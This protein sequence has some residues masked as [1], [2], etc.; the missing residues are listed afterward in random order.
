MTKT[1]RVVALLLCM[2]NYSIAYA[3]VLSQALTDYKL[4]AYQGMVEKLE[5]FKP[6][7]SDLS[8]KF[9]LLGIG[10]NRLQNYEKGATALI[11]AARFKNDSPDLWYELGQALYATSALRKA[12]TAFKKS[13]S[14]NYKKPESLYYVA[15]ISQILED[16]KTARDVYVQ[17]IENPGADSN[18]IQA[19]RFQLG[20]VL[21]SMAETRDDAS[22]LVESYVLPQFIK[23]QEIVPQSDIATEIDA[24]IK[25]IKTRY[26][27]DPNRMRNGRVLPEKRWAIDFQQEIN[28]DNNVTLATDVPTSQ[29]TQKESYVFDST[30]SAQYVSSFK[31]R[32][33][34]EP[35][36]RINQKKYAETSEPTVY[37]NDSYDITAGTVFKIEH[38][39]KE[40]PASFGIGLDYKY[41]A[42]DRL[43]QKDRIY[44]ARSTTLSFFETL[45]LT[46]WG[47]TTFRFKYKDYSAYQS[48]LDNTTKTFAADQI[49]ILPNGTLLIAIIN[50]D[51][52]DVENSRDSTNAY[53]FRVDHLRPNF[54][55]GF[56]LS[57]GL[58]VT[59]LD[60]KEQSDTR[61]TEKTFNP[62]FKL[63]KKLSQNVSMQIT[64]DYTKNTSL[65]TTRYEY[66][67]HVTGLRF[68]VKF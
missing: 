66:T 21:L 7:A 27:L 38:Q 31:G 8:L 25:E 60:T 9:Y 61:G 10:Y 11:Q 5:N 28:F 32:Y 35:N 63:I 15:H 29:A 46:K 55:G 1:T 65:D 43:Q 52:I 18:L 51:F 13:A 39:Y 54:I 12:L 4:G 22:R 24:R 47:D 41:I 59:F 34:L 58:G 2:S 48:S 62:S 56:T 37:Q 50:A 40:Q 53:L 19:S 17:L 16:Y 67:K 42:R 64:Y 68:R 20:E 14:T 26:G 30:L 33:L 3:D 49:A 57:A 45:R 23:A 36:I 6:K 44:Y